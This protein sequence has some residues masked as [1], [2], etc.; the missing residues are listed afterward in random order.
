[1][2]F[3]APFPQGAYEQP[4]AAAALQGAGFVNPNP[5][6]PISP[7]QRPAP[8]VAQPGGGPPPG[9]IPLSLQ[10]PEQQP[11]AAPVNP[12]PYG[13]LVAAN[14]LGTGA[15][16]PAHQAGLS[17]ADKQ[18]LGEVAEVAGAQAQGNAEAA[19]RIREQQRQSA[20]A[21]D[22]FAA[23]SASAVDQ[24]KRD[25]EA[26]RTAREELRQRSRESQS[27]IES[28]L[29]KMQ[30]QG[31]DPNR[32]YENQSTPTK[33][34]AA[35]A[36]GFGAFGA[37]ALGPRGSRG[38]NQA[39]QIIQHAQDQELDAQ[40]VTLQR[41][42]AIMEKR[43]ELSDKGFDKE[44]ALLT[45]E[46][47][48]RQ[49]MNALT[50]QT[51]QQKMALYKDNAQI[52]SAGN[53]MLQGLAEKDAQNMESYSER[54][55]Q[56]KK[57]SEKLVGGGGGGSMAKEVSALAEK[58]AEAHPE[59]TAAEARNKAA[60]IKGL[61]VAEG[62]EPKAVP[63]GGGL[64]RGLVPKAKYEAAAEAAANIE[65]TVKAAPGGFL[66]PSRQA[67]VDAWN[68]EIEEAGGRPIST[69]ITSPGAAAGARATR[70]GFLLHARNIAAGAAGAGPEE[71]LGER[72]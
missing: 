65:R 55:Y 31:V 29:T 44:S 41:Q 2:S 18:R 3:G 63:K 4:G 17:A 69:G 54:G 8:P 34:A 60:A 68:R 67:E 6:T 59:W 13:A 47:E 72:D 30:A 25:A 12:D 9:T 24:A 15:G 33:I 28:E 70:A 62:L 14:T 43:G 52:Q 46:H 51:I 48:S 37:G 35:I 57:A 22:T 58:L 27:R 40:K 10:A 71:E 23:E 16:G 19:D 53:T 66:S 32:Y 1:M 38:E 50:R 42:L 20:Q 45:A 11:A 49:T 56:L 26:E 36:V 61:P 7:I 39:L 21:T 64:G 5:P